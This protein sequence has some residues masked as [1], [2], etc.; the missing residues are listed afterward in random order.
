[1]HFDLVRVK[2]SYTVCRS[3][4]YLHSRSFCKF[5][6]RVVF[7]FIPN[8]CNI[9][10]CAS[11]R[12]LLLQQESWLRVVY[13]AVCS[14]SQRSATCNGV[15]RYRYCRLLRAINIKSDNCPQMTKVITITCDS[16]F[17][18]SMQSHMIL[19]MSHWSSGLTLCFPSQGPWVQNPW[20]DSSET[21]ILLLALSRYIDD[22][23]VIRSLALSPPRC[24]TR[25][26]ADNV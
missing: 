3:I 16:G 20:G 10:L 11:S 8:G 19:T 4:S 9:L 24:F 1:M 5:T 15:L 14:H 13:S 22:P 26:R 12:S 2:S 7:V 21:G 6:A 23:D 17:V 18:E 25:H